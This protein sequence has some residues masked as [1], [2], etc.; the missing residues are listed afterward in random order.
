[1]IKKAAT[2]LVLCLTVAGCSDQFTDRY[3]TLQEARRDQV[4]ERGWL[5]DVLPASSHSLRVSGDVDI[6][7]AQGEFSFRGADFEGFTARLQPAPTE[8]ASDIAERSS[9]L[10]S[11][12]YV[13]RAYV[14]EQYTWMFL[15]SRERERCEYYG[16]PGQ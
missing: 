6:N 2:V 9:D 7:T 10:R 14:D 5:P 11:E 13:A 3:S 16:W 15:C 8:V 4:F 1:M 12:G